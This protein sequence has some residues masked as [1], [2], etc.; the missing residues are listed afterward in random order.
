M[1]SLA[2]VFTDRN[3]SFSSEKLKNNL[4]SSG[5]RFCAKIDDRG[6]IFIPAYARKTLGLS[7]QDIVQANVSI[8]EEE[9]RQRKKL[10]GDGK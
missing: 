4:V 9:L 10:L 6:R 3:A 7:P 2:V 1:S 5:T 8:S